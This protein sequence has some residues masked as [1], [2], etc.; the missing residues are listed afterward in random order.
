[1]SDSF[2]GRLPEVKVSDF[3]NRVSRFRREVHGKLIYKQKNM[4]KNYDQKRKR[5]PTFAVGDLVLVARVFA[6]P[7]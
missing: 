6:L 3:Q 1:M 4:K 2:L 5:P 7:I